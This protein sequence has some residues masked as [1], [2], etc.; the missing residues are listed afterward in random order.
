MRSSTRFR[1]DRK[2]TEEVLGPDPSPL[3]RYEVNYVPN[4]FSK[5]EVD[6]IIEN[7]ILKTVTVS[8]EDQTATA[9][10]NLAKSLGNLARVRGGL[11]TDPVPGAGVE[12]SP[13]T[14]IAKLRMDPTDPVSVARTQHILSHN[15]THGVSLQVTPAP[16]PVTIVPAC[17]YAV[18]YRPLISVT[19][20]FVDK[21]SGN[22][23]EYVVQV[24]DP[25]QITG[26]DIER[27]TFVKRDTVY[28][29][30]EGSLSAVDIT[31]PSELA[32][33][34]LLPLSIVTAV[35]EGTNQA[36]TALLGLGQNEANSSAALLNAQA[37][38]LKALKEYRAVEDD[39]LGTPDAVDDDDDD[40]LPAGKIGEED[41]KDKDKEEDD[42]T[43]RDDEEI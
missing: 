41:D 2:K 30:T 10:V 35:F 33:A 31:K 15:A 24:P 14:L 36:V 19:L 29:F 8:T 16:R 18:C 43:N 39:V 25:H 11:E 26:L 42:D 1:V 17:D 3:F 37:N 34:A 32:A 9:L 21:R 6:F 12:K 27:S 5:D 4:R 13:D 22:V 38:F 20:S 7:Q 40:A 28:T 23:T